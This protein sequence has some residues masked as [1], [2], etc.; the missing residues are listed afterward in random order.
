MSPPDLIEREFGTV[1]GEIAPER[2]HQAGSEWL[3]RPLGYFLNNPGEFDRQVRRI[4]E[5]IRAEGLVVNPDA[6]HL[7][8]PGHTV[9]YVVSLCSE[10]PGESRIRVRT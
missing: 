10:L 3:D 2:L 8:E 9:R 5:R 4:V 6:A 7:L 1:L